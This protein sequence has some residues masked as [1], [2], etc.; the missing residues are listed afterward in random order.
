MA[1]N[2]R[3]AIND[4]DAPALN[5]DGTLKDAM[6]LEF[7]HSPSDA[8]PILPLPPVEIPPPLSLV[9]AQPVRNVDQSKF[10]NAIADSMAPDTPLGTHQ[11]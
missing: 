9:K 8:L 11:S 4:N 3:N 5:P 6:E 10:R 7:F 1:L 2:T